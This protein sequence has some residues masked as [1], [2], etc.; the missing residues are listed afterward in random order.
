MKDCPP[1]KILNPATNRCVSLN[2][3]IGKKLIKPKSPV[4][5][6]QLFIKNL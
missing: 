4:K 5:T 3:A 6:H 1:N 2:G